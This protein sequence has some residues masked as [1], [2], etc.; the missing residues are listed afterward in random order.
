MAKPGDRYPLLIYG[1]TLKRWYPKLFW[2]SP[3]LLIFWYFMPDM[4][5][6]AYR[7]IPKVPCIINNNAIQIGGRAAIEFTALKLEY[8]AIR[9]C[10]GDWRPVQHGYDK[11][12]G[13]GFSVIVRDRQRNSVNAVIQI[14]VR[15][16]F[17]GGGITVSEI[18]FITDNRAL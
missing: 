10:V 2:L 4:F 5:P 13:I 9:A 16:G 12:L 6:V 18:P 7:S 1:H 14:F 17:A 15:Y 11:R 8:P 3:A